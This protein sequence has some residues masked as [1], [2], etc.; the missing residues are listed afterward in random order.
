MYAAE[1]TVSV[2]HGIVVGFDGSDRARC[3][4][5]WAAGEAAAR[6]CPLHVVRVVVHHTPT[7]IAGWVPELVGPDE[8]ERDHIEDQLLAEVDACRAAG[9]DLE[10]HAAMHDG[11]PYARLAEHAD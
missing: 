4:V 11:A 2:W 8:L 1:R 9:V 6:G 5:R 7:V 10:V 3:A